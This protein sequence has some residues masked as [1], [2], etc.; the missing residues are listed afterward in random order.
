MW[1]TRWKLS[2]FSL[3]PVGKNNT[4]FR[5]YLPH[6]GYSQATQ[7]PCIL[8]WMVK[9][10]T[11]AFVCI[12]HIQCNQI[13]QTQGVLRNLSHLSKLKTIFMEKWEMLF[14]CPFCH[15]NLGWTRYLRV[16]FNILFK[17]FSWMYPQHT[18]VSGKGI[19]PV[20]QQWQ[21][22][23]LNPLS[24]PET[25][26]RVHFTLCFIFLPL[27]SNIF[28]DLLSKPRKNFNSHLV[29]PLPPGRWHL[30]PCDIWFLCAGY[31]LLTSPWKAMF[32]HVISAQ[33]D[34]ESNHY[35]YIE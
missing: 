17:K 20:P 33:L 19:T 24:H 22:Q 1:L 35:M 32:E 4:A 14:L 21:H 15:S 30:V 29:Q 12:W 34:H 23:I 3:L 27:T 18:E 5:K 31:I 6:W 7:T 2:S 16:R 10:S 9:P 25:P 11:N 28:M 26:H 13:I 8:F